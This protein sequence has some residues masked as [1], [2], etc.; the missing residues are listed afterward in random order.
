MYRAVL[1]LNQTIVSIE[2]ILYTFYINLTNQTMDS[3]KLNIFLI[4]TIIILLGIIGYF[5]FDRLSQAPTPITEVVQNDN[6]NN[7]I[8]ENQE[9]DKPID[10]RIALT[11]EAIKKYFPQ[12]CAEDLNYDPATETVLYSSKQRGLSVSLP[13]NPKWG[14]EKFKLTPYDEV[15]STISPFPDFIQFGAMSQFEGG[16]CS[17]GWFIRFLPALDFKTRSAQIIKNEDPTTLFL[18]PS[19]Y[20]IGELNIIRYG[21]AGLC[22]YPTLEVIGKKYNYEIQELCGEDGFETLEEIAKTVKLIE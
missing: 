17:R 6:S 22:G 18:K 12:M 4:I 10:N 13:F 3:R 15:K 21:T 2:L 1:K 19:L 7:E 16:G 8:S 9:D 5:I 20:E 14:N 11:P